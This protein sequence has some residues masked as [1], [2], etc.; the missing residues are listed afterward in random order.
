MYKIVKDNKNKVWNYLKADNKQM[1]KILTK[2]MLPI[3]HDFRNLK[4][5]CQLNTHKFL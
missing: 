3:Y 5:H 4:K 1:T 2:D